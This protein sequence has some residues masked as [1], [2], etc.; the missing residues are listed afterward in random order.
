M[1]QSPENRSLEAHKRWLGYLQPDGLVVSAAALVDKGHY[2]NE[3]QRQRQIEFIDHLRERQHYD[4]ENGSVEITDFQSLAVDILEWP[5]Q[6]WIDA[7]DLPD[8]YHLYLKE[9]GET[10]S[11]L[12]ALH[13]PRGQRQN[14]AAD[15]PP[16]QLLLFTSGHP[17][18]DFDAPYETIPNTWLTSATRR[19]ERL[20]RETGVPAG[21]LLSKTALRLVYAPQ[22]EN[23]GHLTFRYA[24]MLSTM[25]RPILGAFELLLGRDMLFLGEAKNQLPALLRHSRSMQASVSTQLAEQVLEALY[26]LVRG[27][28]A[29]DARVH[30]NLLR[31]P[32]ARNPD[33]VYHGQLTVLLRL[34]FLLFA[35]DRGLLP[36]SPLFNQHYSLRALFE[37]LNRDAAL[38]HDTMDQ[39]FGAWPQLLTLFRLIH[40]G[41]KHRDLQMPAREGHL[42]DPDRFPFLEGRADAREDVRS[43]ENRI[44]TVADGVIWR[45]L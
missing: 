42:F 20:L 34:V 32:M 17:Q 22:G 31:Q 16:Y 18:E 4:E 2:Y 5:A 28:Q 8:R 26:E 30:G 29:A 7:T 23:P 19:F 9:S 12:A 40:G 27:F 43:T 6:E 38:H 45:I 41:H 39:R 36:S 13:L 11:P 44:P 10:L 37:R 15:Q 1:S 24:D 14:L 35:E 3:A 33:D 25:G 21:L